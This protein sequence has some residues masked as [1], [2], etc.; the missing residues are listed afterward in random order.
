MS[1][2]AV[3][4]HDQRGVDEGDARRGGQKQMGTYRLGLRNVTM[5]PDLCLDE[6]ICLEENGPTHALAR[7]ERPESSEHLPNEANFSRFQIRVELAVYRSLRSLLRHQM[8]FQA[9]ER[10]ANKCFY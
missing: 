2:H 6:Q 10:L 3:K 7:K 4:R 5:S 9:V 1:L 8:Y